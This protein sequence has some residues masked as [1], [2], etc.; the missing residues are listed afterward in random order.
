M[1]ACYAEVRSLTLGLRKRKP[2]FGMTGEKMA[3][4][5]MTRKNARLLNDKRKGA[6][7]VMTRKKGS[8]RNKQTLFLLLS[9]FFD[10]SSR[11]HS[12][13]RLRVN[14][15]KDLTIEWLHDAMQRGDPSHSVYASVNLRSG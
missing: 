1:A 10:L 7:F 2:P 4:F 8:V 6:R 11:A 12:A 3:R 15:A 14:S 5:G 9:W 13:Y